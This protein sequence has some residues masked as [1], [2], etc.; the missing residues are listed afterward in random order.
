M[1]EEMI[2]MS[3]KKYT[4]IQE[5]INIAGEDDVIQLENIIYTE[6]ISINK[7]IKLVGQEDTVLVLSLHQLHI[8][9]GV[10]VIFENILFSVEPVTYDAHIMVENA[11]MMLIHCD[12]QV[13]NQ[14]RDLYSCIWAESSSVIIAGSNIKSDANLIK[15]VNGDV[16]ELKDN[17]MVI[18]TGN[19]GIEA[20]SMNMVRLQSNNI[21]SAINM[22]RL[23]KVAEFSIEKNTFVSPKE[24]RIL[25]SMFILVDGI[26]HGEIST[27][28]ENIFQTEKTLNI[29]LRNS[30]TVNRKIEFIGNTVISE[31]IKANIKFEMI[32]GMVVIGQNKLPGCQ[33]SIGKS[34]EVMIKKN[35]LSLLLCVNNRQL[36]IADNEN[37]KQVSID[38]SYYTNIKNNQI[39]NDVNDADALR[40]VGI[41]KLV[42]EHN[43][44]SSVDHG[45]T[46]LNAGDNLETVIQKNEFSNCRKRSINI[47]STAQKKY[48]KTEIQINNNV[49][50][51]NDKAVHL[52]DKNLK[53]CHMEENYFGDNQEAIVIFGGKSTSGIK[54][55]GN[56][57][58]ATAQ[59][60]EVRNGEL[61]QLSHNALNDSKMQ[62]RGCDEIIM[63]GNLIDNPHYRKGKFLH[64]DVCIKSGGRLTISHNTMLKGKIKQAKKEIYEHLNITS[65]EKNPAVNI[66]D[67]IQL[68][69][70]RKKSF[71]DTELPQELKLYPDESLLSMLRYEGDAEHNLNIVDMDDMMRKNFFEIRDAFSDL[72]DRVMSNVVS[73]SISDVLDVFQM[74]VLAGRDS[75]DIYRFIA[76]SNETVEMLKIYTNMEDNIDTN[77]ERRI[78][79]V[80]NNYLM[81]VNQFLNKTTEDE[82]DKL[83]AQLNLL[84]NLL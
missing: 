71:F 11:L 33:V 72:K 67:N 40:L 32:Q 5:A 35:Q 10:Q 1:N 16:L 45:M 57:F 76:K 58:L 4:S 50:L 54:I 64:N 62:L 20:H 44:I 24:P 84:E 61:C 81:V 75:N 37:L 6:P 15:C 79:S 47:A 13:L 74:D 19:V 22:L 8:K 56:Y 12:I 63:H 25:K 29:T 36:M 9:D 46:L 23:S 38:T 77:T 7:S 65:Y 70:Y 49:F 83:K 48:L 53:S 26:E 39:S 30:M 51:N 55:I 60:I 41:D 28:K 52:D 34:S 18:S 80:M 68:E 17:N 82:E 78:V 66:H 31:G 69:G 21:S 59:K 43:R 73:K 14:K 3:S 42:I 2:L 27:I